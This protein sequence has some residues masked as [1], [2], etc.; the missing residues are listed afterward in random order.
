MAELRE[1][2]YKASSKKAQNCQTEVT[3]LGYS[4]RE[5]KWWL[6][7]AWKKTVTQIPIPTSLKQ[8]REFVGMAGF[9][10]LQIPSFATLAATLYPFTKETGTFSWTPIHQQ[11]FKEI[12]KA[13]LSAPALALQD[14]TKPVTLYRGMSRN[15]KWGSDLSSGAKKTTCETLVQK[16]KKKKKEKK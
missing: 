4:L 8:V 1:L 11:A 12:K 14:L 10:R 13:L 15:R 16:K 9:C 2:G 6:T 5:R 7:E 3:Y